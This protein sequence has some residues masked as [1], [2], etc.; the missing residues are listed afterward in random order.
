M[1]S[2]P[3][4]GQ[5]RPVPASG[6]RDA[7]TGTRRARTVDRSSRRKLDS[8]NGDGT[9]GGRRSRSR[10]LLAMFVMVACLGGIL[11]RL[12]L[13]QG[14]DAAKYQADARS[15]YVHEISFLGERGAILDRNGDELAM[16]VPM[17]T[18]YA[19]PYQ[20]TNPLNEAE[21][22]APMLGTTVS[23]LQEE[24][25]EASGFV[26]LARTVPDDTAAK[27]EKLINGGHMVGI[28]TMQE[29]KRFDPAGQLA[30]PLVGVVGTDGQGL[31]G[32]EY[33][34]NSLLEGRPGRLIEDMDPAGGQIPG[35]LQQYQAPVRGDDLVVSIDEPLQYDTEEALARAIVAAQ[36]QSG[37]AL[38]MDSR[39]GDLLAL[40]QLT[41]PTAGEPVTMEEPPA[42]PVW[43]VPPDLN[44][45]G[46]AGSEKHVAALQPVEAPTASAFTDVYE[47]GSVEKLVTI[48]AALNTGAIA[49]TEYFSVP[50]S[51]EVDGSIFSDAWAHPTLEW[52]ASNIL[53]H[54]S[55]IGS[56]EI[57]Q[58]LGMNRLLPYINSFGIG[59][60]SD[61]DF[62]G[63]S[64]GLVPRPSQWSGTTIATV[65]IGQGL[66]VTAVQMLAAYNT[67]AEGGTY[68]PPKL[69]DG[70]ID[71]EGNEHL[72]PS[73]PTH[74]VVSPLVAREMTSMLE[75]VVRVGT[76]M[77]ASLEPYTVAGKT[78]T[79]LVPSP[80]GGYI[81][82]DFVSSFAGFVPA[83]DPAIT[84]M[85]VV[86]GTHQ[87]GAEASAPVF[88]MIARDALQELGVPPHKTEPPIPGVPEASVYG[89]E[90]EAAG[91]ALPGLS[92]APN[93]LVSSGPGSPRTTSTTTVP[94]TSTTVA[95]AT[96][97][98]PVGGTSTAPA[99]VT[100]TGTV[101]TTAPA[102]ATTTTTS[103]ETITTAPSATTSASAATTTVAAATTSAT[104]TAPPAATT[105][106]A[107]ATV[108]ATTTS[109]TAPAV[110]TTAPAVTT[111]APAVTTTAPAA[112][113]TTTPA[114]TVPPASSVP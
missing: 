5:R 58:Q 103:S 100:T 46:Q 26:Y 10:H 33:K 70:Y 42:L 113:T 101:T 12:L 80:Q 31:S 81:A 34:Y 35:G 13:V 6:A 64:V 8:N 38:I 62:P 76:G 109:A 102:A 29:P 68:I 48:S 108:A 19:D 16:S 55:D 72:F 61:I 41:M 14:V 15:E 112:A 114:T 17:T 88:A 3:K 54:S 87:Y 20:V 24:L 56:I 59:E 63:E 69:V 25:S 84:A 90:G 37:M 40:A 66:A 21:A 50:N 43:F 67:I 27:V 96:T 94:V 107:T 45:S 93:V 44:T 78:G 98:A 11:A 105:T 4:A 22:L 79:A 32:L 77:A 36:A 82:N 85:V 51:Y 9:G 49:P 111:T 65:P 106:S 74:R 30:A 89:G 83:E 60:K 52:T 110:T 2:S 75:G 71:A 28:Y 95:A 47:P 86:E 92:G 39:T 7:S 97:T 53:A 23:A 57:A 99:T 73:A 91:P 18:V 1:T 104:T